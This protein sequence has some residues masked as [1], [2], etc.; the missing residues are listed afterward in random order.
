MTCVARDPD[1]SE[2][3]WYDL[4]AGKCSV[5]SANDTHVIY[6]IAVDSAVLFTSVPYQKVL[7]PSQ[8]AELSN[9]SHYDGKAVILS[10]GV[11]GQMHLYVGKGSVRAD[12]K[13]QLVGERLAG[14]NHE[15]LGA[16]VDCVLDE[17]ESVEGAS[18]VGFG[19]CTF[20][21]DG[22]IEAT[23]Q[24]AYGFSGAGV[25]FPVN[26]TTALTLFKGVNAATYTKDGTYEVFTITQINQT[27]V[28][29]VTYFS[30]RLQTWPT[31][32]S[33][34]EKLVDDCSLFIDDPCGPGRHI[35]CSI[36]Y[37]YCAENHASSG[38]RRRSGLNS[39]HHSLMY[40]PA[41]PLPLLAS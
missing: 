2:L 30:N 32:Y 10:Y 7:N 14:A 22:R 39:H 20:S 18:A 31:D 35:W 3:L 37:C 8:T 33:L 1:E 38:V 29:G 34:G 5:T 40:S 41:D 9:M 15:I 27:H 24:A 6:E 4:E 36:T 21:G 17:V 26:A 12:G 25:L 23:L 28:S 11:G 16:P 19:Q 13:G